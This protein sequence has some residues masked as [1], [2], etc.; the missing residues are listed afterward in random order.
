[1]TDPIREDVR[2]A[3]SALI[4]QRRTVAQA[5]EEFASAIR[6]AVHLGVPVAEV[7]E[8]AGITRARVYQ[9]RD[10]RR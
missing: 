6:G 4:E 2:R 3:A 8:L 7:A 1:M 9:I 5:E 10:G